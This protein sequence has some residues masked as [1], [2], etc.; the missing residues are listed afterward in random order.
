[1]AFL[2]TFVKVR[3]R[4]AGLIVAEWLGGGAWGVKCG[5]KCQPSGTRH[6]NVETPEPLPVR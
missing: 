2:V 3:G 4:V 6:P 5:G 1:M